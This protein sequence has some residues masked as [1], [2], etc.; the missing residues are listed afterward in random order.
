MNMIKIMNVNEGVQFKDYDLYSSL[1]MGLRDLSQEASLLLPKIKGRKIWMVNSTDQGGGVAEM[2]PRLISLFRQ[3]GVDCEWVVAGTDNKDFFSITKKV[4]NLIHG[5]EVPTINNHEKDIY[6]AVN[7][8]NAEELLK[9]LKPNDILVMH[10]PQPMAMAIYLKEKIDVK[11]IWRCH[12]GFDIHTHQTEAAWEFLRPYSYV[13]SLAVF[14]AP[15]YIQGYFSGKAMVMYPSIDP[16]D[17]KNRDLAI[18]KVVGVLCNSNLV[19]EYHPVLTPP[20]TDPV[21]RLQ[22]DG[23]FQSPL[24]PSDIG[25]LFK[26]IVLQISRWDR[27]KGFLPLM[28]GFVELKKNIADYSSSSPRNIRRIEMSQLV[29]AGPDPDYVKDDPEGSIVLKELV[30]NYLSLDSYIQPCITI[31]KLPMSSRKNNELIVN[32]LQRVASIIVQNSLKEG[33][34]LTVTEA[35]WKGKPVIG[36]STCGI[37]QQIRD[38]LDGQLIQNSQNIQEIAYKINY[39][40]EKPKESE[41]WGYYAQK[42]VIEK[43]LIFTQ[44]RQWLRLFASL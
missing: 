42:R 8:E 23:S 39:A 3:L 5:E 32:A 13:Y 22:P 15:E 2:M 21:K 36:S 14:S 29:L 11:F 33:F 10:D 27:L 35:M 31:L 9:L 30:Q 17:H 1:A 43:Y 37:K 44:I 16:L 38:G 6:E 4:H 25:L 12:I 41:V 19:T 24:L 26:P 28:N 7:K 18:H 40:L 34:G 20:F